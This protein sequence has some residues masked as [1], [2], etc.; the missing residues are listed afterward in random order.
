MMGVTWLVPRLVGKNSL[1][2]KSRFVR[3]VHDFA[4]PEA[5][6]MGEKPIFFFPF[7]N[8]HMRIRSSFAD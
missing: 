8:H 4:N 5:A 2:E 1:R 3:S 6:G 7:V